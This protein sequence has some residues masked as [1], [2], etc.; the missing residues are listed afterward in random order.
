[1]IRALYTAASGM[2]AQQANIDNIAHNLSNV[3]TA[4]F[5]KARVEFED[6]VYDQSKQAGSPTSATGEAPIG[7]EIGLGTRPVATARD[8]GR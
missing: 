2:N 8:F 1:M 3:N 7:F 5:K 6:L 4:G